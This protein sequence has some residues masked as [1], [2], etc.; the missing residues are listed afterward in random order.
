[1]KRC[2]LITILFLL[3][4]LNIIPVDA[5]SLIQLEK[6]YEQ[7]SNQYI[8]EKVIYDSLRNV[9]SSRTNEIDAEKKKANPD[10][11]KIVDLMAGSITLSNR[12]EEQN[13]KISLLE[14]D[15]DNVK[16][17]LHKQYS[18]LIDSLELKKKTDKKNDDVLDAE[19]LNNTE[20]KLLVAPQIPILSFKPEKILKIDLGK[21]KS[22]E[23]KALYKEYLDNALNEV[24]TLLENVG[25]QSS[26]ADQVFALQNKTKKFLEET[27]L[28]SRIM[29][30]SQQ[31]TVRSEETVPTFSNSPEDVATSNDLSRQVKNYH[32]ILRQLDIEQ[33]SRTNINWKVSFDEMERNL[34]LKDYQKLLKEVKK[35]LQ[36]FKLVLANKI[37]SAG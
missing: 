19:I 15:I 17:Q 9:F 28:E 34:S 13:K 4:G 36:E 12:I 30:R 8:K 20:K 26:E 27:E 25:K 37:G 35:R 7:L 22:A 32:V 23:E 14:K 24:N 10:K 33:L 21:T 29:I 16:Q 31:S 6:K 5:Q 1:M 11:D 2:R 3:V 18:S